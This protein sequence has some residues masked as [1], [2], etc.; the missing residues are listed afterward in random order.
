MMKNKLTNMT[1][2]TGEYEVHYTK[3]NV[4]LTSKAVLRKATWTDWRRI[5]TPHY[6]NGSKYIQLTNYYFSKR[7]YVDGCMGSEHAM[8]TRN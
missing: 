1:S 7:K 4:D 3:C 5:K 6:A 8:D 2:P